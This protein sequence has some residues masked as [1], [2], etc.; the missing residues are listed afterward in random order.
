MTKRTRIL[1]GVAVALLAAAVFF[2]SGTTGAPALWALSGEGRWL[3]PLVLASALIDS[4]NPC[5]FSVLLLTIAFLLS[6][7]R[8]RSELLRI[9]GWYI[10]GIG[11]VYL[12]IGLGLLQ[13]LHLFDTP[14]FMGRLAAALLVL[15]GLLQIANALIPNFPLRIRIPHL[16]HGRI[17][18]LMASATAPAAFAL[19]ALVGLCE[20]PCTGGPYLM[21][22]GLLHDRAT[23]FRGVGYL[24][25]YNAVFVLPLV[26]TLV[27]AATPSVVERL[28]AWHQSDRKWVRLIGGIA[29]IALA[30]LTLTL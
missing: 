21:V 15:L 22:L 30:L 13:A 2:R 19:G 28:Q 17:A 20:F 14:H 1:I 9:G 10:A 8:L 7:G 4:V 18:A 3:L 11:V 27:L 5:A 24:V 12:L 25:L 23:Y 6:I 16:A 26:V 29:M